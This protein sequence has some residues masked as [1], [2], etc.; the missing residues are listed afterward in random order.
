MTRRAIA[1]VLWT[2][3]TALVALS[4]G[5]CA[6]EGEDRHDV[7]GE[8]LPGRYESEDGKYWIEIDADGTVPSFV[9]TGKEDA[10]ISCE[11]AIKQTR[12]F[13]GEWFVLSTGSFYVSV[14]QGD[15]RHDLQLYPSH[16]K[17]WSTLIYY[18]CDPDSGGVELKYL[19][20]A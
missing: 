20:N 13:Q 5:G 12:T 7:Q 9:I 4:L 11:Q 14:R 8:V 2:L 10:D 3:A 17:D 1:P 16:G 19:G 6:S 18:P 15:S